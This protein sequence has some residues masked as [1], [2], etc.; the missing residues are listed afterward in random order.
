MCVNAYGRQWYQ[1]NHDRERAKRYAYFQDNHAENLIRQKV[2]R[3]ANKE[4]VNEAIAD[5]QKRNP[6][7]RIGYQRAYE[8]RHPGRRAQISL[9]Y[10]QRNPEK[11]LARARHW[12]ENNR[13]TQRQACRNWARNNPEKRQAKL[14]DYV[15]KKLRSKPAWGHPSKIRAVYAEATRLTKETGQLHHVDHIVPLRSKI[16]CGLHWEG[17]LQVLPHLENQRKGNR[18]W[19]GMP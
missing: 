19:P 17:N 8:A 1:E 16:V 9:R 18:I 6:E 10:R 12:R 7:K 15:A 2:Y 4:R 13:E 14:A 11:T 5:W 3:D